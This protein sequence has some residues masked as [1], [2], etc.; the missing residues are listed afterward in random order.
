[1]K[2]PRLAS[3]AAIDAEWT[4]N[5]PLRTDYERRAALV[6][7]DALVAVWLG[8]DANELEAIYRSRYPIL[9]DRE[10]H[11][12]FDATGRRIAADSYAFGHGQ[13]KEHYQQVAAH[14]EGGAPPPEDYTAPFYKADRPAEMKAAHAV[15][16]KRL[17]EAGGQ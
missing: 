13:T 9:S 10:E 8:I 16:S 11:M 7:L 4:W 2:W 15:F 6:E 1:M 3:L 17:A 5:S 14:M 12:Y